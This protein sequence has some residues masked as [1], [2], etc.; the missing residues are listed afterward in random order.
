LVHLRWRHAR[1]DEISNFCG[2]SGPLRR[3]QAQPLIGKDKV[4]PHALAVRIQESQIVLS[5]GP[6]LIGGK[7]IPL[8]R[9]SI[10]LRHALAIGIHSPNAE[11]GGGG[12]FIGRRLLKKPEGG[13]VVAS[14]MRN[15]T[16]L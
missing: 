10:I 6:A 1:C 13:R 14:V 4:L 3:R 5:I 8:R 16:I 2:L 7:A 9:L 11:L 12:T 15:Y